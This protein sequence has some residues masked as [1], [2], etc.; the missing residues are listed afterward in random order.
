ES[1]R[2]FLKLSPIL[3]VVTNIDR[4]HMDCY[5][6]MADVEQTFIAFMERVPFYG[7]VVACND[8]DALRALLPRVTR[9]VVT[10]GMRPGSDFLISDLPAAEGPARS[11]FRVSFGGRDGRRDLGDFRLHVPGRHNVLNAAAAIAVGE[12]L[13]ISTDAI[14]AALESFRGVD[15]R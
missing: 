5:R 14:R 15:R 8:D 12:G 2:S 6:D 10:Y 13:A 3:S 7:M 1:D 4:E 11:R 9:R